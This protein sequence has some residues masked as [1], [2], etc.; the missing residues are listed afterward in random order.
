MRNHAILEGHCQGS[1]W[2]RKIINYGPE[3]NIDKGTTYGVNTPPTP[4]TSIHRLLDTRNDIV[5]QV[6]YGMN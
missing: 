5:P 1:I 3:C 2:I 6:D 4:Q